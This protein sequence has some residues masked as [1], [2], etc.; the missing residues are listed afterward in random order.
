MITKVAF[1][2]ELQTLVSFVT[3]LFVTSEVERRKLYFL[4]KHTPVI[5][6]ILRLREIIVYIVVPGFSFILS[7]SECNRC[8]SG[9]Q[10]HSKMEID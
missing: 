4:V 10:L 7:K 9:T 6:F 5:C 2:H 8:R 1:L 3:Q